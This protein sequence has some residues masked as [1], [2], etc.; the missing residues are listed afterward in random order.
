M[1]QHKANPSLYS[2]QEISNESYNDTYKIITTATYGFDSVSNSFSPN[3]SDIVYDY[4]AATY[5]LATQEVYTYKTGGAS[6]T[7][8]RVVTVTYTDSTKATLSSVQRT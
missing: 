4:I 7:T 5:P 1:T 8:T 2:N 6:G 3:Q